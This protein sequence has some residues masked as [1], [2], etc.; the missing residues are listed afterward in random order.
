MSDFTDLPDLA[1]ETLGGWAMWANDEFFA[2][3][4]NLLRPH[5]A[6]WREHEYTDNGKWMDGWETRRRRTPGSD[7]C[8]IRLGLPGAVAGIVV[9]TAYFRG[10]Y[11][12]ECLIEGATLDVK[13]EL[14][15]C[16]GIDLY[17]AFVIALQAGWIQSPVIS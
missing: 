7:V 17:V 10:N 14:I 15:E 8:V 16:H 2:A 12:A 4:E 13:H 5:A 9:D 3:K 1:S 11:P 6:E